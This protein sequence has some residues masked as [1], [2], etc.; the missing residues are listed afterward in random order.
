ME[1]WRKGKK[2]SMIHREIVGKFT[3]TDYARPLTGGFLVR[4]GTGGDEEEVSSFF[5]SLR[6]LLVGL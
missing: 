2:G 1:G 3:L 4:E 6:N 5:S